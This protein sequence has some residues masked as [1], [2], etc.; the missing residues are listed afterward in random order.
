MKEEKETA[1]IASVSKVVCGGGYKE[2]SDANG[3][4][5]ITI[6]IAGFGDKRRCSRQKRGTRL[7]ALFMLSLLL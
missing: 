4:T 3:A 2:D 6:T 7:V 5:P 1:E